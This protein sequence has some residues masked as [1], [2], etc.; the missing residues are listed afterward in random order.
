MACRLSTCMGVSC[1]SG[2]AMEGDDGMVAVNSVDVEGPSNEPLNEEIIV[3]RAGVLADG[4]LNCG[5]SCLVSHRG[6]TRG[7][8]GKMSGHGQSH[9]HDVIAPYPTPNCFLLD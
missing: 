2:V 3:Q 8:S 1:V 6:Q 9:V 7:S 5:C 4:R